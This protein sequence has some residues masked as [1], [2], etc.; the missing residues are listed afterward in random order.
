MHESDTALKFNLRRQRV[1]QVDLF[2]RLVLV[3]LAVAPGS[4]F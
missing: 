1:N 2:A 4:D 3:V